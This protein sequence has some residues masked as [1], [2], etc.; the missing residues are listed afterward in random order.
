[1][2]S[3]QESHMLDAKGQLAS[4]PDPAACEFCR[5]DPLQGLDTCLRGATF[6][7]CLEIQ[8]HHIES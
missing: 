6:E 5:M 4:R 2:R 1:M 7:G 8:E 3:L